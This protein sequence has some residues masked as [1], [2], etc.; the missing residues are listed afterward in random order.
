MLRS[1]SARRRGRPGCPAGWCEA[2]IV[3]LVDGDARGEA[4][5]AM[6]DKTKNITDDESES[7]LD[8]SDGNI[9]EEE[10]FSDDEEMHPPEYY[11]TQ[12]ATLDPT[13][14]RSLR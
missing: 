8:E 1:A 5:L 10:L 11:L 7:V 6:D 12:A 3:L 9:E 2:D 14:L 13:R 4:Q